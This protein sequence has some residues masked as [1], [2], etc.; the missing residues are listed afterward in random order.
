MAED[1]SEREMPSNGT[2][3]IG[4]GTIRKVGAALGVLAVAIL[5]GL[6]AA[7]QRRDTSGHVR[8][9]QIGYEAGRPMRAYLM[10]M[11]P[12]TGARFEVRNPQGKAVYSADIG[13]L[14]GSWGKYNVYALDFTTSAAD[15]YTVTVTGPAPGTSPSFRVGAPAQ[16]YSEALAN[17]LS[18]YQNQRDGAEFI[19]SA[20]RP[21]ASHLKDQKA[22]VYTTPDFYLAGSRIKGDLSATGTTIDAS[23]GWW[24]AGDYLKFVHTTSY[25]VAL[26]LVG[27]RDF[28]QQIGVGSSAS[29]FTKEAKFGLDWLQRMWD[30]KSRTLYYQV[31]IGSRASG[32][33]DDHSIWRLPDVDDTYGGT[34]SRY[35]YIR[36][37]PAFIAAPRGSKI[38]PNLAGRL[39]GDFALC[40][41]IYRTSDAAYAS[42]CLLSAQHIFDLADTTPAGHLLTAAPYD[43]YGESE[44]R[45]DMEFGAT[46][47][48]LAMRL[49]NLPGA[50]PH[51]DPQFYLQAAA[52]FASAYI[53]LADQAKDT[54]I[55]SDI[56]GLAHFDLYRA[57]ALAGNHDGLAVSQADLLDDIRKKLDAAVGRAGKDPF[58]YG[59]AWGVGDTP[60]HGAGLAVMASEYDYL[61]NSK[62]YGD[63][64]R[65]WTGNILGAN[66]W[67][68]SFIV[69]DGSTFPH[70]IHHQVANLAGSKNGEPPILT[71]ALVE[72]P[73]ESADNGA[74]NGL[75]KCPPDGGDLFSRFDGN[76]AK[77]RDNAKYYSSAEPAIDLTAPSLLLFS[78]QIA[79]APS[80]VP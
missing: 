14:L 44:W 7:S 17:A 24:D 58:G 75:A 11:K 39:A 72:G 22:R 13:G 48:Y 60:S 79:G 8:V 2:N 23:G 76:G 74:P 78:W 55:L 34:D 67:G 70:C 21:A 36:N 59:F 61:I 47:L 32:A 29:D 46:E 37:R 69:G 9:N 64:A 45:D 35:R 68:T 31:G 57:L 1:G 20:L 30:D 77:Y 41:R 5:L 50:L 6:L 65:G 12:E 62:A 19:P 38:S 56:S 71:G 28:P 52:N 42:Q 40:F 4:G 33:E 3:R 66:A 43:F 54:L 63:Y 49:G 25:T 16:L 80:G 51:S 10:A 73:V 18:F 26:M 27:V 53:H 15:T